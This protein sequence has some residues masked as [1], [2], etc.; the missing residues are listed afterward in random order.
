MR[1]PKT[2]RLPYKKMIEAIDEIV[3]NDWG[4]TVNEIPIG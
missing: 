4:F 3:N 1:P 2:R